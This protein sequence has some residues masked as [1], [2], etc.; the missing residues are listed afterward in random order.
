MNMGIDNIP[1]AWILSALL[2]RREVAPDVYMLVPLHHDQ[3]TIVLRNN[4][5]ARQTA[6]ARPM[7]EEGSAVRR[8]NLKLMYY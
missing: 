6:F 2:T 3:L 8:Y 1:Q 4:L 5:P 7:L